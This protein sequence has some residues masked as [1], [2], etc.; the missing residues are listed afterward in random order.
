MGETEKTLPFKP[1]KRPFDEREAT[2]LR[3]RSAELKKFAVDFMLPVAIGAVAALMLRYLV[4]PLFPTKGLWGG[5]RARL[6]ERDSIPVVCMFLLF[7][8]LSHVLIRYFLRILP[9]VRIFADDPIP[10]GANELGDKDLQAIAH[11][12]VEIERQRGTSILTKR[13]L[14]AVARLGIKRD[15]AELG[16]LLRQRADADRYRTANAYAIPGYIVWAIP[17][18]GFVGTVL[19]IGEAVIG[20]RASVGVGELNDLGKLGREIGKVCDGLGIAFDT[21]LVALVMSIVALGVQTL[22]SHKEERLLADVEDYLTYRL[23]SRIKSESEDSRMDDVMRV[24]VAKL[25][26]IQENMDR[27]AGE[28]A[29]VTMQAMLN[30]QE[31]IHN[32]MTLMP[33]MLEQAGSSSA[34]KVGEAMQ[35]QMDLSERIVNTLESGAA[36]LSARMADDFREAA[37][38]LGASMKEV[39]DSLA[40]VFEAGDK[41]AALQV[42]LQDSLDQLARVRGLS[43]T[44]A[45]V[46]DTLGRMHHVLEK[47]DR[48]IPLTFT[49]GGLAVG[50]Q[51][52]EPPTG[53]DSGV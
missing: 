50:P 24:A 30:A 47:L 37:V 44:M 12:S 21:T 5:V 19:G 11:R 2:R 42:V 20:L 10:A 28:R 17:I 8:H 36:Q 40:R 13:I 46:R 39:A 6:C 18:L 16:D 53:E 33:Q 52:E 48:P 27:Q 41:L 3:R 43:D 49:L 14:L 22:I 51:G 38:T 7:W 26:D 25:I 31:S 34:S 9:E 1:G 4:L 32:T 35:N 15:T 45:E 23:Q 29:S